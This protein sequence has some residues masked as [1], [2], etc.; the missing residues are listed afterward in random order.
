ML[1]KAAVLLVSTWIALVIGEVALRAMFPR[2]HEYYVRPPH[3]RRVFR[4]LPGIMP[5]VEGES[6][7]ITNS[8]GVRADELTAD[9]TYHILA[10]GG[11]TTE[12]LY[13]D[14]DEAWPHLLQT[15]LNENQHAYKVWVGNV[16]KS[17][18]NTRDHIVQLRYLLN[19]YENIDAVILLVGVND[20][21]SR[22]RQDAGYDPN[23]LQRA[24]AEQQL[25][26]R[27]F[28]IVSDK[29]LPFYKKTALWRLLRDVK[30]YAF[31]PQYAEGETQD[32][33]GKIYATWRERRRNAAA[34]RQTLPDLNTALAEY[35]GNI[36]TIIDL[37][38]HK[39]VRLI[40]VTQPVLWQ[41]DI[42]E[43]LNALL[44]I[45]G[46]GD[47]QKEAGKEYYSV[48]ALATAMGLYNETLIKT[49]RE[50]QAECF[51][52][53]SLMPKDTTAFYDDV[54][55][56]EGGARKVAEALTEYLTKA[57]SFQRVSWQ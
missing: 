34:I 47:F 15:S 4:P 9:V 56:N 32:E 31:P 19:Q 11:S 29:S 20:L 3:M 52:L 10:V 43:E 26:R 21:T 18:L 42:P 48:D 6:R 14:Q 36:N 24:D 25:L 27:N 30:T 54:H 37:T 46:V 38:R 55:L 1:V 44:W 17:G 7:Y 12:C 39:S 8:E 16:G 40:L 2:P 33:A 50:R 51:D 45:G 57:H 22:L 41:R 53:A 28:S 49:C 5:G 13:L 35:A 23:F